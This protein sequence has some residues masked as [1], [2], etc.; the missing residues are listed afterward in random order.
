MLE[1]LASGPGFVY[2][3][4]WFRSDGVTLY[5]EAIRRRTDPD[6]PEAEARELLRHAQW[7]SERLTAESDAFRTQVHALTRRCAVIED[8]GMGT[9]MLCE[10]EAGEIRWSRAA[11]SRGAPPAY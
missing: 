4:V 1:Q 5:C 3:D 6:M 9:V 11:G 8:Y 7:A 2:E 10:L